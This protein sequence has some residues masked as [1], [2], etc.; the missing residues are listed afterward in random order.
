MSVAASNPDHYRDA[1]IHI[2]GNG[3]DEYAEKATGYEVLLDTVPSESHHLYLAQVVS[4]TARN[5][6]LSEIFTFPTRG[7]VDENLIRL[8]IG[9]AGPPITEA[10]WDTS[11]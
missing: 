11:G 9:Y 6:P 8:E 4:D 7:N 3:V 2:W 10:E 1:A 5:H